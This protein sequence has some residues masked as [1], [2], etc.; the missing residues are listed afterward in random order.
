MSPEHDTFEPDEL[1]ICL[2]HYDLGEVRRVVAFPR[3]SPRSPKVVIDCEHGKYLLK[4]RPR[5]RDEPAKVE[6]AHRLQMYLAAQNFP[7][8]HLIGTRR[9]NDT[10]IVHE[11]AIYELFELVE[12]G[13]YKRTPEATISAGRTMGLFHKLTQDYHAAGFPSGGSY[14]DSQIIR[15]AINNT[16]ASLPDHPSPSDTVAGVAEGLGTDYAMAAESVNEQGL[17]NW[18]GQIVH[19]DWHPGNMLFRQGKV[20]AVLDYDSARVLQRAIDLANGALQFSIL[21]GGQ[22]PGDWP[23]Q[24]DLPRYKQFLRGYDSVNVIS[25]AELQALPFLMCEAMIA[26]AVLP[27]AATGTFGRFQGLGF[28]QMIHRKVDWVIQHADYLTEVLGA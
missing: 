28:L 25:Q 27:I 12:G 21:A 13:A 23:S 6:C 17:W 26:E 14:H 2:S 24:L 4:R 8:P 5:G 18:H 3:G 15:Q 19:G 11:G 9:H 22:E 7:L 16:L 20:A 10:M 1:A